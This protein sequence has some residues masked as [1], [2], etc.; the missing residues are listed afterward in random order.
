MTRQASG[1][2]RVQTS[3]K[4]V[5]P[6]PRMKERRSAGAGFSGLSGIKRRGMEKCEPPLRKYPILGGLT[7]VGFGLASGVGLPAIFIASSLGSRFETRAF[8]IVG[9]AIA[10]VYVPASAAIGAWIGWV[11]GEKARADSE[12][13]FTRATASLIRAF[14]QQWSY[15]VLAALALLFAIGG[16]TYAAYLHLTGNA[17]CLETARLNG[18]L[19]CVRTSWFMAK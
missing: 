18:R 1:R 5:I 7:G 12:F 2:R 10:L 9:G 6:R 4:W 15:R 13:R 14:F 8:L 17:A 16:G 3:M 19:E 11:I